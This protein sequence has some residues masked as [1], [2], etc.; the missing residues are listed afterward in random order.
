[1]VDASSVANATKQSFEKVSDALS[2]VYA[3]GIEKKEQQLEPEMAELLGALAEER[4]FLSKGIVLLNFSGISFVVLRD[5]REA[6]FQ[7][8]QVKTWPIYNRPGTMSI[9]NPGYVEST[10]SKSLD[11]YWPGG[12]RAVPVESTS[13]GGVLLAGRSYACDIKQDEAVAT[14]CGGTYEVEGD[15]VVFHF[16]DQ[17][18]RVTVKP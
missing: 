15:N 3:I 17:T 16:E 11:E 13:L 8:T 10:R 4:Y 14:A 5:G 6:A 1:M 12:Y 2:V 18:Y 9:P 7:Q